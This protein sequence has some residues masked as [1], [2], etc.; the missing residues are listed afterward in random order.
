VE[1]RVPFSRQLIG[2]AFIDAG[3]AWGSDFQFTPGTDTAFTQHES[4]SP[5]IGVGVGVLWVTTFGALR[6]DVARGEDT[7][8]HFAFGEI[9]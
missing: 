5:R 4:F 3:D 9:F 8:V 1:Y 7:R 2:A 6:L